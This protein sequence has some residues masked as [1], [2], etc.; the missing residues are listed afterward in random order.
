[1]STCPAC[2][3][4]NDEG[5]C[6]DHFHTLLA[7]EWEYNLM[8]VHHLLVLC[9]H[10]QHP[11]L[12]SAQVLANG[13]NMLVDFV[14]GGL[15]PQQMRKKIAPDVNSRRRTYKITGTVENHGAYVQPIAWTMTIADVVA[16]GHEAYYASVNAWARATL[17]ALREA[18]EIP[19]Q[20]TR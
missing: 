9:Y 12:Y 18:G 19:M 7:W 20:R 14:E 11:H 15:T 8:E 4:P 3:A 13:L 6:A 5:S 2:G 17:A 10:L 16:A 1:M